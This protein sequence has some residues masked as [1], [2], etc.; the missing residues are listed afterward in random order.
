M[1]YVVLFELNNNIYDGPENFKGDI[2]GERVIIKK[3]RMVMKVAR[4]FEQL[5]RDTLYS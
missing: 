1:V 5:H 4:T 3:F 2:L